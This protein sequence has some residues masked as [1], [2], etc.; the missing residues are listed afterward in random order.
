MIA[1]P[2]RPDEGVLARNMRSLL[3]VSK[4]LGAEAR[5]DS[6]LAVVTAEATQVM[7]AE[8]SSIFIYDEASR[9]LSIR[10]S[11]DVA[12]GQI[13]IPDGVG[14][15]GH[16]AKTRQTLNVPDAYS[17]PRFN[18]QFDKDTGF[19][20]RSILCAPV[21]NVSGD[22]VGVI[23][24]LNKV[25]ADGF[26]ADDEALLAA[27]ASIAGIALDRARLVEAFLEKEK[28]ES[29]LRLAH[30]IQMGMLPREFPSRS[31]LDLYADLRPARSVGG[32][33]Y[34]FRLEGD[35]LWFAVGD[36]SGKGVPAALFMAVTKVLFGVAV[37][38]ESGP[39]AVL[40]RMNRALCRQNEHALFVSAF[41]GRLDLATGELAYANAGHNLPYRLR[42]DGTVS[43]LPASA[44]L[45]LALA[46]EFEFRAESV[47]L[48]PGDMV[49]LYTDG[50]TEAIDA[51]NVLFSDRRLEEFLATSGG[52]PASELVEGAIA[53][54]D[55]FAGGAPQFDDITA[56]AVRWRPG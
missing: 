52:R 6:L 14:I 33:L 34:D 8:R 30:D 39:A 40:A 11:E 26:T 9:T 18:R 42:S 50:V 56:L 36:V 2:E 23:Q 12:Q 10:A 53:A 5:L 32:D 29:S 45:V 15:A 13:R 7:E 17:D 22:L 19:R 4:A 16:V 38:V 3:E 44:G 31:G 37:E 20:T 28:I 43:P 1:G 54:V 41:V 46:E 35:R 25:G 55:A 27:F 24:I 47:R 21:V 51:G 48:D 49:F